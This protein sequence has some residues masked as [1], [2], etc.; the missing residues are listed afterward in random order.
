MQS[1]EF[2]PKMAKSSHPVTSLKALMGKGYVQCKSSILEPLS[3]LF[4][5]L[6]YFKFGN[7]KVSPT[8]ICVSGIYIFEELSNG[9]K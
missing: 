9:T 6:R 8:I 3:Y 5:N 7:L 2:S 1:I 4:S